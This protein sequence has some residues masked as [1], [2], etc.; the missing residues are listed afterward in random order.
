[1]YS[2]SIY[3][4]GAAQTV[5][6]HLYGD[7]TN[8]AVE[9]VPGVDAPSITWNFFLTI[10]TANPVSPTSSLSYTH[11]CYPAHELYIGTQ[12]IYG[13]LP[14]KSDPASVGFCL[15]GFNQVSGSIKEAVN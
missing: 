15:A 2:Y 1:L 9:G 13:Y 7:A 10:S 5:T 14:A 3:S 11:A 6:A 12:R 8:R 4:G